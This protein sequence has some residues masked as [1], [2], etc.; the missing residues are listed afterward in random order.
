MNRIAKAKLRQKYQERHLD[1]NCKQCEHCDYE[2][3]TK[4]GLKMPLCAKGDFYVDPKAV[5]DL[6]ERQYEKETA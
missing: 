6:F 1:C 5:C 4:Y 2:T 3:V